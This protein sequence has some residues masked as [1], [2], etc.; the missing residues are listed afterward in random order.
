[1]NPF[2]IAAISVVLIVALVTLI[3]QRDSIAYSVIIAL[4][5]LS[6]VIVDY[7]NCS[8]LQTMCEPDALNA[9]GDLIYTF[10]VMVPSGFIYALLSE[11]IKNKCNKHVS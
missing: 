1:M 8:V 10:M 11:F 2:L 3:K 7:I 5:I 6:T 4:S 9:V